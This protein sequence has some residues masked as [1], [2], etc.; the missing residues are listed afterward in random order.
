MS[1]YADIQKV[2]Q[3]PQTDENVVFVRRKESNTVKRNPKLKKFKPPQNANL[4]DY[5]CNDGPHDVLQERSIHENEIA[6]SIIEANCGVNYSNEKLEEHW[7]LRQMKASLKSKDCT[8]K[9]NL[10]SDTCDYKNSTTETCNGISMLETS[11]KDKNNIEN[12]ESTL[13]KCGLNKNAVIKG[14][15]KS[16]TISI[17]DLHI[18]NDCTN[19]RQNNI[20]NE[21]VPS[22][23]SLSQ[24]NCM[25]LIPF[26]EDPEVLVQ[27]LQVHGHI[28][29]NKYKNIDFSVA[30]IGKKKAITARQFFINMSDSE[31]DFVKP[32]KMD[33]K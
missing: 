5:D 11:T 23:S 19:I 21:N 13:K 33:K 32:H 1:L 26:P 20:Q 8:F 22:S 25:K 6:S 2:T 10:K 29:E 4:Y 31:F 12:V 7:K 3:I 28:D 24:E 30:H 15:L 18:P 9:E 14:L 16:H 17:N 27:S